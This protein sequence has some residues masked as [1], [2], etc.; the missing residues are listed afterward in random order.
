MIDNPA[1]KI[2]LIME[3][4]RQG[5][6][7]TDVLSAVERVSR[8]AFVP[9][10]FRDR[11]YEN[12]ALPISSGQTISQPYVVAYMTQLLKLDKRRKVLEI[13]T[14]SGYQAAILARLCRR[15]YSIERY[16]N[17][18]E[19][20]EAVFEDLKITNITTRYGDGYKGWP[21]QAPFDRIIVTAASEEVPEALLDQ[22]GHDGIMIL[23]VGKDSADQ[24]ILRVTKDEKGN[25]S[26]EVLLP[27]R[28][29]PMV[30]GV[31]E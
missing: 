9:K 21:E 17:L 29:V 20:A 10:T 5:I 19:T 4:R 6:S 24:H 25:V 23:P 14:G 30:Q 12:I 11:A 15:V 16:R 8:D 31:A 3:L 1:Q 13:G 27:V 2:R 18:L 28:F 26:E 7:N 22:L